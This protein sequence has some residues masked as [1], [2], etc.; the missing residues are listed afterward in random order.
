MSG[1]FSDW[2]F[3]HAQYAQAL[4]G[5]T[6]DID[7]VLCGASPFI[8]PLLG[9]SRTGKTAVLNDLQAYFKDHRSQS[10]RAAVLYVSMPAHASNESLAIQI[11]KAILGPV[12]RRGKAHQVIEQAR[13]C[14][15]IAG[16]KVLLIDEVNHL[17][18]KR[19]SERAQTKELR[20]AADWFKEL[21]D[22][23]QLSIVLA[24]LPHVDRI[25][26][27]NEQLKNRGLVPLALYPYAWGVPS[28]RTEY[29]N[30]IS[31][32][33]DLFKERGW[34]IAVDE[35]FLLRLSYF[36]SGGYVGRATDFLARIETVGKARKVLDHSLLDKAYRDK[37]VLDSRGNPIELKKL[38][39]VLLNGAHNE[40]K[41]RAYIPSRRSR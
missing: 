16:I 13:E 38:D 33:V 11:I 22:M 28:D 39:D 27:D 20:H 25:Y 8:R 5:L 4:D 24:G 6:S 30:L 34:S 1:I 40:A 31:A 26:T 7:A 21:V 17:V 12:G 9:D 37:H 19:V 29:T 10:G 2:I 35:D 15:M 23:S 3:D 41:Q 18:E 32:A 36:G 14:L